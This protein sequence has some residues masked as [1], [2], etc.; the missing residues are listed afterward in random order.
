M[1][2]DV[3]IVGGGIAGVSIAERLSREVAR[4]GGSID[5]V[6][7]ESAS[8]L[9]T[10][11]SGRLEGWYHSGTLYSGF[12][13]P[14]CFEAAMAG[15]EDLRRWY[16]Q[17]EA[18]EG[19]SA[20]NLDSAGKDGGWFFEPIDYVL[21]SHMLRAGSPQT[22]HALMMSRAKTAT[23]R[24]RAVASY[25]TIDDFDVMSSMDRVMDSQRIV[26][27]LADAAWSRGVRFETDAH[28][29]EVNRRGDRFVASVDGLGSI[30]AG[31]VVIC[32]GHGLAKEMNGHVPPSVTIER[33]RS[34]M[35][36]SGRALCDGSF[37]HVGASAEEDFSHLKHPMSPMHSYSVVA[38]SNSLPLE[39]PEEFEFEAARCLMRKAERFLGED[40]WAEQNVRCY[41]CAKVEAAG[42]DRGQY[43]PWIEASGEG[44]A[45]CV[46]P[47]K[48][49]MFATVAH[50][51][52]EE[53]KRRGVH[54]SRRAP[55]ERH[56]SLRP[57]VEAGYARQ[58]AQ[59]CREVELTPLARSRHAS[60]LFR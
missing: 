28:V 40:V 27:D 55:H 25:L 2:C 30:S 1:M 34:V 48:F 49:S 51:V 8:A 43:E 15:M 33:R 35:V 17:D 58:L 38:D 50:Q 46:L 18:F 36:V 56:A 12:D 29:R 11:A 42:G 21:P 4:A 16:A 22:R 5:I 19:R 53:L 39:C 32:A 45:L 20:C 13:D 47:G 54:S 59:A 23:D 14:R 9:G 57:R 31:E 6:L 26:Q 37:V 3:L 24:R 41:S 60:S 52:T 7:V 44:G 10:G